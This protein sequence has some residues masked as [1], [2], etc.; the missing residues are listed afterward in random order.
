V[1]H[2]FNVTFHASVQ[3]RLINIV[4]FQF[5]FSVALL[6]RLPTVL[7]DTW[8]WIQGIHNKNTSS[9]STP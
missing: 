6:F 3:L 9:V 1:F 4:L 8:Q 5:D 2:T 7:H